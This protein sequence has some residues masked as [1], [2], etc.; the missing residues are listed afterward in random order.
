[1]KNYKFRKFM[2]DMFKEYIPYEELPKVDLEWLAIE[3]KSKLLREK[4]AQTEEGREFFEACDEIA[5]ECEEEG[6]PSHGVNY[7]LR[8]ENLKKEMNII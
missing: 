6:Y 3:A 4:F 8:V 7:S 1:M 2:W 5:R